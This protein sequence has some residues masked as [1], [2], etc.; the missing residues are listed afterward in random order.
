MTAG[1][2]LV[3]LVVCIFGAYLLNKLIGGSN[4]DDYDDFLDGI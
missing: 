2:I 3:W 4:D 1:Y